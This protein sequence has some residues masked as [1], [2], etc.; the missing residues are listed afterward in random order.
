MKMAQAMGLHSLPAISLVENRS[1]RQNGKRSSLLIQT[2]RAAD[3][4]RE[5]W[6]VILKKKGHTMNTIRG[7]TFVLSALAVLIAAMP[8]SAQTA[9]QPMNCKDT[10][11]QTGTTL[12]AI[13]DM[14]R[15]DSVMKEMAMASEMMGKKDEAGCMVHMQNAM[16]IMQAPH[17]MTK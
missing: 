3:P 2:L 13:T 12:N 16:R 15:K 11:A 9:T 6:T 14:A 1:E 5:I 17:V 4:G 8:V 10:M 7:T